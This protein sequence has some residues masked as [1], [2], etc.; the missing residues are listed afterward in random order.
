MKWIPVTKRLPA[1]GE[2]VLCFFKIGDFEYRV[3]GYIASISTTQF[4]NKEVHI[5]IDWRTGEDCINPT[6]W[7]QLPEPPQERKEE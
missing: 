7:A 2:E 4:K 6:H 5:S 1:I 3:I